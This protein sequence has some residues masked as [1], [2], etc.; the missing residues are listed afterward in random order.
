MHTVRAQRE[1]DGHFPTV[2][3]PN[4][5]EPGALDLLL[6]L[7]A[8]K[9]ADLAI[10]NDPDVDRLAIAVPTPSGRWVAPTRA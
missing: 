8:E 4:P 1:P 5:E 9:S 10:A 3:F 2:P 7:A 6:A